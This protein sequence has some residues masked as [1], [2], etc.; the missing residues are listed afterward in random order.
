MQ[1]KQDKTRHALQQAA[2]PQTKAELMSATGLKKGQID[3]T[4]TA[5]LNAGMIAT[6]HPNP[7]SPGQ[8]YRLVPGSQG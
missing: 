3:P 7:R 4:I 6:T 8:C 2:G 5:M 1:A